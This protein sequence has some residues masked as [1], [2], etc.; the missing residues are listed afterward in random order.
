MYGFALIIT[1]SCVDTGWM[2]AIIDSKHSPQSC[3]NLEKKDDWS[4]P[5]AF[6]STWDNYSGYSPKSAANIDLK[7]PDK[8]NAE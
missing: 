6:T 3:V 5:Q 1:F 8:K 2:Y 7:S 4:S